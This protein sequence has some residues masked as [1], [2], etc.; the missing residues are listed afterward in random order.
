M[1]MIAEGPFKGERVELIQNSLGIMNRL[2]PSALYELELNFISMHIRKYIER[3]ET[4]EG[5]EQHLFD[6][7]KLIDNRQYENTIDFYKNLDDK[8]KYEFFNELVE[9]GIPIL[10]PPFWGN[11]SLEKMTELYKTYPEVQEFK[12]EGIHKPIIMGEMYM[13]VLKH[14]TKGKMSV[15]STS[16]NS[17]NGLPAKSKA[18]RDHKLPWSSTPLRLG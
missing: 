14:D 10:Q 16:L 13:M 11:I 12:F 3:E 9:K 5:K 2:I 17:I 1:P 18:Y 7:L 8:S 4:L 6:Y 15:R